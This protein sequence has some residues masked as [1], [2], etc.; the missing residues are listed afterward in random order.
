MARKIPW[1]EN[2]PRFDI[3]IPRFV[4]A[5]EKTKYHL[6]MEIWL[7][8]AAEVKKL[9]YMDILRFQEIFTLPLYIQLEYYLS[10]ENSLIVT[11]ERH[12]EDTTSPNLS[13]VILWPAS[14]ANERASIIIYGFSDS[15][16]YQ[17]R[18]LRRMINNFRIIENLR[19]IISRQAFDD[20]AWDSLDE[21]SSD[22]DDYDGD[23]Y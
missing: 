2:P 22:D 21:R 3:P 10:D 6:P 17:E 4:K 14:E 1:I 7:M 20:F 5:F 18:C 11:V 15:Q 9:V 13:R 19:S 12:Y 23:Y 8:I 16:Q